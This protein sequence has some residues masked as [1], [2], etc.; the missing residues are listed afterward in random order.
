MI[1]VTGSTGL[2]GAHLLYQLAGKGEKVKALIRNPDKIKQVKHVFSY[3]SDHAGQ[4]I[5]TIEWIR[6]DIL[7]PA[8]YF[9]ALK[10]VKTVYHC[11]AM[12][13]FDKKHKTELL[14]TNIEGTANIVNA[15]L[16][17]RIEKFCFVSSIAALGN[18][19]NGE[20]VTEENSWS[21]TKI[22]SFYALSKFKSEMEV[23]RGVQEGLNA[24][25]VNPSVILG[26]GFWNSGSGLIFIKAVRG[27][28]FYTTGTTGF[29]DVRDVVYAMIKLSESSISNQRFILNGENIVYKDLLDKISEAVSVRKPTIK[30][31]RTMLNIA[32]RVDGLLSNLGIKKRELTKD[33]V[34]S[35]LSKSQYSSQKI[36]QSLKMNFIPVQKTIDEMAQFYK[37]DLTGN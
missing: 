3:Y 9:D 8:S 35:S 20:A 37:Q 22:H 25:I 1:F 14:K 28:L 29:V 2:V 7:D 18:A 12:V 30:A 24:V 32:R 26:P 19:Q 16:E 13:S 23:W 11:A 21:P 36:M 5:D 4:L 17:H 33:L 27:M 10:D 6:G 34:K 31:T 15:S